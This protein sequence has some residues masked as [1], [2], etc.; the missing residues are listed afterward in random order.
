[1]RAVHFIEG[2]G[3][4]LA[5]FAFVAGTVSLLISAR[6]KWAIKARAKV[7]ER[8]VAQYMDL[9]SLDAMIWRFW[10]WDVE[11]FLP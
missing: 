6:V 9:P 3:L 2:V 10:I 8:S 11:D 7:F 5:G 4:G 1:M